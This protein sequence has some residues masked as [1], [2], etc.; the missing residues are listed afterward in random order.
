MSTQDRPKDWNKLSDEELMELYQASD[1]KAFETL[2]KRHEGRIYAYLTS[3][4]GA[5]VGEELLQETF[6]RVHKARDSYNAQFPFLP[7]IFT[8]IRNLLRDHY[9]RA[10]TK[11]S[12]NSVGL[13]TL[14]IEAPNSIAEAMTV[15]Q[16]EVSLSGLPES[17][18][19]ALK[20]RYLDDWSF[21]KIAKEIETSPQNVRQLISRGLKKVKAT[22]NTQGEGHEK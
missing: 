10:E 8:I 3:K 4:V 7:W 5:E 17:Q 16:L 6:T 18:Q 20:L 15:Q 14:S 22:L 11:T 9:K 19:R 13:E 21:E 2:Y 1:F 12:Q